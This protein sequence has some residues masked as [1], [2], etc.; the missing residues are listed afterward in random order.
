MYGRCLARSRM[1]IR[2]RACC[3]QPMLEKLNITGRLP[4][5]A[6]VCSG[7]SRVSVWAQAGAQVVLSSTD[8]D[9]SARKQLL[10]RVMRIWLPCRCGGARVHA[11]NLHMHSHAHSDA[12]R[13]LVVDELPSPV[14]AQVSRAALALWV[15]G[16]N[17]ACHRPTAGDS[18]TKGRPTMRQRRSVHRTSL[19]H[20]L[21]RS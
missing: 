15:C 18:S 19:S 10:E 3:L 16:R 12:L 6:Q 2:R 1:H 7:A 5:E 11:C 13:D 9:S 17:V 21:D 20:C 4:K 8:L 14:Q